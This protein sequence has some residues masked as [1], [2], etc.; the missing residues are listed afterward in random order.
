[1]AIGSAVLAARDMNPEVLAVGGFHDELVKI[2]IMLN[3]VEPLA[4]SL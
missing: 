3:P 2:A 1:M 4:G